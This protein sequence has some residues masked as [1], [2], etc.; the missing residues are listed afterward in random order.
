MPNHVGLF[1]QITTDLKS[2]KEFPPQVMQ[3]DGASV[4]CDVLEIVYNRETWK[5]EESTVK[6]WIDARRLVVVKEEFSELQ[7][8]GDDSVLWHWVYTVD[9]VKLNQPPPE[10][11]V[12]ESTTRRDHPRPEWVGRD[13]PDFSLLDLDGRQVKLSA[14]RG[15]VV[16]L[17]FWATWCGPCR[18]ELPILE[19]IRDEYKAKAVEFWG[20]SDEE[21][22]KVKYWM[23]RNKTNLSTVIDPE[24][25][26]SDQY[27]VDGIPALI[28]IG[29][30][31]KILSYYTGPQ[32]EQSLRSAIDLALNGSPT[33]DK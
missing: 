32:T 28:V 26:T 1:E 30:D 14:M 15:K 29:R 21:P 6:Y 18:E 11:L 4:H 31:G 24:T 5:P 13:A 10:W 17:D 12:A 8:R 9:S 3:V 2:Q 25:K 33:T 27:K 23:A 19:K 16:V 22:S 7:R 20:I